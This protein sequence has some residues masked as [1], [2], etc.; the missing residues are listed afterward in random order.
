MENIIE[1]GNIMQMSDGE[2]KPITEKQAKTEL[3]KS[4]PRPVFFEGEE[5]IIKGG[6]F[7]VHGIRPKKIILKSL[8]Y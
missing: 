6:K 1:K 7:K 3:K 5:L 8:G 2:M 4:K